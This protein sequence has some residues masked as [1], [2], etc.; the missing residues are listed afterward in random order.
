[1]KICRICKNTKNLN[2]FSKSKG[3]KDGRRGECKECTNLKHKDWSDKN[4]EIVKVQ[5][6]RS[7]HKNKHKHKEKYKE[8]NKAWVRNNYERKLIHNENRRARLLNAEGSFSCKEWEDLC[9]KFGYKCLA[10]KEETTLTIDHIVPLSKGG[11]NYISNIQPLCQPCNST[12][13]AN[14]IDYRIC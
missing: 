13:R 6:I 7:Y 12:K 1:M 2:D 5:G 9:V 11:S 10:C 3:C 8:R 4:R 14:I